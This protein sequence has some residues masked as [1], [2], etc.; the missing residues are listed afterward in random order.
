MSIRMLM[1]WLFATLA[2]AMMAWAGQRYL[3]GNP[4]IWRLFFLAVV[5]G[6]IAGHINGHALGVREGNPD[7]NFR[8]WVAREHWRG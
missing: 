5:G 4:D 8:N 1:D 3:G 7:K 2:F 6:F